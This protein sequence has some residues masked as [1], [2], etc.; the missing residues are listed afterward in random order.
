MGIRTLVNSLATL[1]QGKNEESSGAKSKPSALWH[2]PRTQ[3]APCPSESL[4]V[5]DPKALAGCRRSN[6]TS[7]RSSGN[8]GGL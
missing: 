3:D 4:Q 8:A 6:A 1:R 7:G 5:V 2:A